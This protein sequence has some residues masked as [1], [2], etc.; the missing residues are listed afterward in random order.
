MT[1]KTDK[2]VKTDN[3]CGMTVG[4]PIIKKQV[5]M[6]V[7]RNN[8]NSKSRNIDGNLPQHSKRCSFKVKKNSE[9]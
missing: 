8:S 3:N 7:E 4:V 2:I 6:I 9:N 5:N 1:P